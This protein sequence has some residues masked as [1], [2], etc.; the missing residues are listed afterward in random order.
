MRSIPRKVAAAVG[1]IALSA[2]MAIIVPAA[3][4]A[5]VAADAP[6]VI[7]EVYGG[8]GNSGAT[9]TNDFIEL[10][11][12]SGADVDL[13][14]WSL[15]YAGASG[16][17]SNAHALSGVIKSGGYFLIQ[18]A[19]GNGG[20]TPLPT[21]DAT[22]TLAMGG[23]GGKVA[24]VHGTAALTCGSNCT[25]DPTVVDFVGWGSANDAA[26]G[27]AAPA[28]TNTQSVTRDASH[29]NTGDNAAD[30]VL[31]DPPTPT[32]CG[33]ACQAPPPVDEGAK[34]IAEIQGTGNTSP[35]AGNT[36]TT[37]GIVTAAYPTGGYNGY[38]I[39]TPGSGG[40]IDFPSHTASDALFVYSAA[41][42][43]SVTI[44]E[45]VQVTGAVSEFNGLTE[46][47]VASGGMTR[48][49]EAVPAVKPITAAWPRTD[50]QRESI[51]SM[52]F[53]G[54]GGYTITNTYSTNQYGEVGLA[55]GNKPLIQWTDQARPGTPEADA[56]K[57]DNV[58]RAVVLDDGA[59]TNFLSAAN[60]SQTPPYISLDKPVR[61]GE[62]VTFVSD[63]IVD[64]R[65]NAW[66]LQPT[67]QVTPGNTAAYPATWNDTRTAHPDE[68][69]IARDGTPDIRAAS[70]NVLNFFT[71]T[72]V[73]YIADGGT[74]T[75]YNDRVGN[76]ITVNTCSGSGPRGAWDDANLERQYAKTVAAITASGANVVGLMEIENSV[77]VGEIKDTT[78]KFLVDRLNA[79]AGADTW[80]YVSPDES[81]L[82]PLDEMDVINNAIIYQPAVVTPD[83]AT[84]MLADQSA[85]GQAFAN[86][87]EPIAQVFQ[88]KAG[89][90]PFI[91]AVNHFKSKGSGSG[92]GNADIGDGQGASNA[93][94]VAQAHAL[95]DWLATVESETGVDAVI[96]VGDYNSYGQEDPMQVLYDAGYVDAEHQFDL[97]KYSYSFSGL[98]GSLDHALL[99]QAALG[100][101]T[102]ADIWNINSPESIALEYSRYNY[103]G[104]LFYEPDPYASSDHDPVIVGLRATA[105]D[106]AGD[107]TV[108]I[109]GINDF[110]GRIQANG[111]EAGAAVLAGAVDELKADHPNTVFSA[112]GD[113]IG[114]ST[115]ESFIAHDKPT[116]D[117]LNAAGLEVSA[118]GNHEFDQGYDDLVNRVMA[119]Y[120]ATTNPYG[121][122]Q[123]KYLGANVKFKDSGDPALDPT[124]VKDIG[125]VKVGFVGAVTE[126]LGE[127]VSPAGIA[128]LTITDIADAVNKEADDL[129]ASGQ[130]DIVVMLVHEGSPTTSCDAV[131][132]PANDFGKIVT[133]L[134]AN[135][136]AVISGHTHLTYN[137]MVDVPEWQDRA[138]TE[139]PVVSAGQYGYNLDQLLFTVSPDKQVTK[140]ES[141]TLALTKQ[142]DDPAKPGT[143]IWVA[144]YAPDG[145]VGQI[146]A[147][148]VANAA[149]LGAQP[150]GQ[151]AGPFNRAKDSVGVENRGGESTL[152]NL[153]AE[154]QRWAT[155]STTTGSAQIAFMNPGGL[156]ADMVG[157]D[158]DGYPATLT[159]QQA[160]TVQPFANT[161]VNMTLTGAQIKTVLEQQWQPAGASRPFLRLGISKGF[162]YTYDPAAAAANHIT[163]M[164]LDGTPIDPAATYSVTVNSFLASGGDNFLELAA[165]T[166]KKDTG[167]TDLQG[168]VDY[169][170][171]NAPAGSP[172]PVDNSQRSVGVHFAADVPAEYAPGDAV[173]FDLS[174]LAMS[175][176]TATDDSVS[177]S[178]GDQVLG[179]FPVNNAVAAGDKFDEV[180]TASV[181]VIL[182]AETPAG[183]AALTV[184]GDTTGTTAT[185]SIAVASGGSAPDA[186][187]VTLDAQRTSQQYGLGNGT[188][189]TAWVELTAGS[190]KKVPVQFLDNGEL[191]ATAVTNGAGKA[192]YWLPKNAAVG[193]HSITAQYRLADGDVLVGAPVVVTVAP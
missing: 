46:L 85:D 57:A 146:V 189:I 61:V 131:T 191:V 42:V 50:A 97:G 94:R 144:N 173:S 102:G 25:T 105:S 53:A 95:V 170:A 98:S 136:D 109:L 182:P 168:M 161:L 185:V 106:T 19:K 35:L 103:H 2:G 117:A 34:T 111:Q 55:Y 24:L 187:V 14:G 141:N 79:A 184:A 1:A 119:P 167:Q 16:G 92:P 121:G 175:T 69:T 164:W 127:L 110:H 139:R 150:L 140:I 165:G 54:D 132:D 143:K 181:T 130:A 45:Y 155:E 49:T 138:V 137:C 88:P 13:A 149:V 147:T 108:Q 154:A 107:T 134:D 113:L 44:G 36:V 125:G 40:D 8:G 91:F 118:V 166:N 71:E 123:W 67:S 81:A 84:R 172:L 76:P 177:V 65:N 38:V 135:V 43:E 23:S 32:A 193:E 190:T 10:F 112:A 30:F 129:K 5:A 3:A 156:R 159:Y 186:G 51:E 39:Q 72:G 176:G 60:S 180:G 116:I 9:L 174:S 73:K 171:A 145:T 62:T 101:A 157:S 128:N 7:N 47:T 120:N 104:T 169:M 74:C 115:F 26:G 56:I 21:P 59:S 37:K 52:L 27:H 82:P 178:L 17:F 100:R 93:D 68:A 80:A 142:V 48:L 6:V 18:E 33:E 192:D 41:T 89:G 64:Y 4:D 162:A 75:S 160:A 124:W 83:G 66:K 28:T 153:V 86:A 90:D 12:V 58:A 158:A 126:H 70:F 63:V 29:T 11:N 152:G 148:A 183:T 96:S 179:T 20:T 188:K 133:R 163:A 151:I 77:K 122:A 87:R 22:G 31:A 78:V 99:N 15:Q 114:A